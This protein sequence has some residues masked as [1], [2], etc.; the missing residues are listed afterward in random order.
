MCLFLD[1][2][3]F[4]DI[5]IKC[6]WIKLFMPIQRDPEEIEGVANKYEEKIETMY[7]KLFKNRDKT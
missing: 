7:V 5:Q 6:V 2:K 4:R 3:Y 1:P